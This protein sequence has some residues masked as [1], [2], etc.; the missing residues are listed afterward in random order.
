MH[1]EVAS[2]AGKFLT[3]TFGEPGVQGVVT[4][5]QGIGV[6][7]PRAATVAAATIGLAGDMHMPNVGMLAIGTQSMMFAAGGPCAVVVGTTTASAAGAAPIVQVN[8]DP[9]F[10]NFPAM[11]NPSGVKVAAP[12]MLRKPAGWWAWPQ[13]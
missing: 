8:N 3:S 1:F 9:A 6:S 12:Q 5:M 2:S 11:T 13:G 10:T 7:T 4:G